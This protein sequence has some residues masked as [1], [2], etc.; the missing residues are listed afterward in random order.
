MLLSLAWAT[1][2]Y[3]F[4]CYIKRT[5]ILITQV[6]KEDCMTTLYYTLTFYGTIFFLR[7]LI[8]VPLC[9]YR[10][11]PIIP[12]NFS[13]FGRF[14]IKPQAVVKLTAKRKTESESVVTCLLR[15]ID[16]QFQFDFAPLARHLYCRG[17]VKQWPCKTII[18]HFSEIH[19]RLD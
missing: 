6:L 2:V 19:T 12:D 3:S 11:L 13:N 16:E 9:K 10:F 7:S 4:E 8:T 5:C 17:H 14:F 15:K 1:C 18:V